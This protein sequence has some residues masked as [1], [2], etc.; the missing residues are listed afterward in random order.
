MPRCGFAQASVYQLATAVRA[1][2]I[3]DE[4]ALT[5]AHE[6]ADYAKARGIHEQDILPRMDEW[7]VYPRLAV[8]SAMKAQEQGMARVREDA[9]QLH[10]RAVAVIKNARDATSL[11]MKSGFIAQV[12][13]GS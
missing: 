13:E 1:R 4:M 11:L 7:E 9:A 5:V 6:L 12:P 8:A 3:T 2:T 10:Q